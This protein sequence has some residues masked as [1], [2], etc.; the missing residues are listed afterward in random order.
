M[1]NHE[2][3][4]EHHEAVH[5]HHHEAPME[6]RGD[7]DREEYRR[8]GR[9][10]SPYMLPLSILVSAVLIAAGMFY[11]TK[12]LV[13]HLSGQTVA[14]GTQTAGGAADAGQQPAAPTG[15]VNITLKDGTPFLGN[16]DAKVTVVEF[17]DYQCPFCE[18]WYKTVWPELKSKYV[19]TGKIKFVY[20]DFAFLGA[21]STTAS[22]AA[23][24]AEEQGKFWEYHDYLF[25]NQGTENTGWATAD[26]QKEFAKALKLNTS[27]FNQ[28]LDKH[29]YAQEVQDQ[30][31][32]GRSYGVTGTP[33][34]FVNGNMIVGAQA[35]N[36]FT[37]AIDAELNK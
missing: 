6:V 12:T 2:E 22:E 24:C 37:Q 34:V 4:R 1:E 25:N 19:D 29:T 27:K 35:A 20:Q 5:A 14:A 17:A 33:T 11:N 8:P 36:V 7:F 9:P 30:T 21:D 18:Q 13:S 15:P 10:A 32:A 16:A 31:S 3:H 23:Q 26:H 28:C